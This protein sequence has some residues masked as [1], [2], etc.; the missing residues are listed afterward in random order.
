LWE[1]FIA[2]DDTRMG[3]GDRLV[4]HGDPFTALDL[5]RRRPTGSSRQPPTFVLRALA[6]TGEWNGVEADVGMLADEL[7][8]YYL[9]RDPIRPR[10]Q[11]RLYWTVCYALLAQ[12]LAFARDSDEFRPL[13]L[14]LKRYHERRQKTTQGPDLVPLSAVIEGLCEERI[15]PDRCF[16]SSSPYASRTR[17][18]LE[19]GRWSG[20]GLQWHLEL[21]HLITLQRNFAAA[22]SNSHQD[23][24]RT[25]TQVVFHSVATNATVNALRAVQTEIDAL[26]GKPLVQ[27]QKL[28]EGSRRKVTVRAGRHNPSDKALEVRLLRGTTPELH[29]PARQALVEALVDNRYDTVPNRS[30]QER[31]MEFAASAFKLLTVR[32]AEFNA[33]RFASRAVADPHTTFL[34]FVEFADRA[35][36]L[37][38]VLLVAQEHAIDDRKIMR[39]IS[40]LRSWDWALARQSADWTAGN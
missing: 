29:R 35:R 27:V 33:R 22:L 37:E 30:T 9:G 11:E 21:S 13:I 32:P 5:W 1:S 28:L 6:D 16:E 7:A 8:G 39:V 14:L 15:L 20:R 4:D 36:V 40:T 19:R 31:I 17:L 34:T 2:G 10:Q 12:P 25:G 23:V 3:E 26:H 18:H 24:I 38:S